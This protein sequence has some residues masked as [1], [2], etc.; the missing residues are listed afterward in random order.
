MET[1]PKQESETE[2]S[3]VEPNWQDVSKT[4]DRIGIPEDPKQRVEDIRNNFSEGRSLEAL[5]QAVHQVLVPHVESVPVDRRMTVVTSEGEVTEL[6]EPEK[7]SALFD[8]AADLI[9]KL[10]ETYSEGNE[11]Q[12]LERVSNIVALTIVMAHSYSD[13]N[14]RTARLIGGLIRN[15]RQKDEKNDEENEKELRELGKNRQKTGKV[16]YSYLPKS[17]SGLNPE[18]TLDVAA[19]LDLDWDNN[20]EYNERQRASFTI[21]FG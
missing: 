13:G 8:H 11:E 17:S 3:P 18:E 2:S 14:G 20:G 1:L 10:S 12:F 21:P 9:K 4:L 16:V 15:G 19:S 7:R 5:T 6:L